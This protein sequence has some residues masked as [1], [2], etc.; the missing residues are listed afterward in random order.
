MHSVQRWPGLPSEV[1][2]DSNAG[3]SVMATP[4]GVWPRWWALQRSILLTRTAPWGQWTW[5]WTGAALTADLYMSTSTGPHSSLG[6]TGSQW[7]SPFFIGWDRVSYTGTV[8]YMSHSGAHCHLALFP[9]ALFLSFRISPT[10]CCC[11]CCFWT[12]FPHFLMFLHICRNC[13]TAL[14]NCLIVLI[15]FVCGI[16]VFICVCS[17]AGTGC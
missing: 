4:W 11:C 13:E 5:Q 1:A 12:Y 9:S 8:D 3:C 10:P 16:V 2:V 6:S 15:I 7:F 14:I 17:I